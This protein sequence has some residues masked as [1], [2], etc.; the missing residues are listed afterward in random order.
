[1]SAF[2]A[3]IMAF[4][5]LLECDGKGFILALILFSVAQIKYKMK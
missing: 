2:I 4:Y 5:Y 3:F 1:M